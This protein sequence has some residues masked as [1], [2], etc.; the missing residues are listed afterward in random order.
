MPDVSRSLKVWNVPQAER[1]YAKFLLVVG[2][3]VLLDQISKD[4]VLRTLP[5]GQSLEVVP[6]FFSLTHIRNTGGAF[7]ILAGRASGLRT[8]FFLAIS[9]LALAVVCYLY[10]R[11]A[12]GKSWVTTAL[13]L[14]FG[15]AVGNLVDRVR[16]GEVV[17]FLDLYA[18]NA[19]WPAFNVADSAISIGVAILCVQ[20]VRRRI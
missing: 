3:T 7:G 14:V 12:K 8:V 16:F 18:G 1:Q 11:T 4:M 6:G 13:C 10:F 15:G 20:V 5:L 19:H 2:L 17:D 9:G